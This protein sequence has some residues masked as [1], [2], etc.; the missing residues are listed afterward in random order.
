ML[1]AC[2]TGR[3]R[4]LKTGHE[5]GFA[6]QLLRRGSPTVVAALY[7][8]PDRLAIEFAELFYYLADED[9]LAAGLRETRHVLAGDGCHPSAWASFVLFGCPNVRLNAPHVSRGHDLAQRGSS[10]SR[11]RRRCAFRAGAGPPRAGRAP[12]SQTRRTIA[13]DLDKLEEGDASYFRP[14]LLSADREFG[15]RI[16]AQ[17][18]DRLL[19][20]FGLVRHARLENHEQREQYERAGIGEALV[21]S[22]ILGD[23]YLHIAAVVELRKRLLFPGQKNMDL[24]IASRRLR[25]LSGEGARLSAARSVIDP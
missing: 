1:S 25:W 3:S 13:T 20:I 16:Q 8:V 9:N 10:L 4:Q 17:I 12:A 23:T 22:Q 24:L 18:V 11:D 6:T 19:R 5:Q 21:A 14:E 15:D 2:L 7:L